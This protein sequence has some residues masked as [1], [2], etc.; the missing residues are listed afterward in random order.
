MR[1][2]LLVNYRWCT[3]C[4]SCELACQAKNDLPAGQYGIKLNEVG[5]WQISEKKWQYSCFPLLTDQCHLCADK[6]AS[7]T[8]PSCVQVCQASC[9]QVVDV[10]TAA[11]AMK[12]N[13]ELLFM[14][15]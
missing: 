13:G 3:G 9:L 5:P 12:E 14:V 7:G 6:L 2:G 10:D 4:H 8:E 11:K 15:L 1:K